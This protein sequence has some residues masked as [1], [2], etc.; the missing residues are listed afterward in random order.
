MET[1]TCGKKVL[2]WTIG[3][4]VVPPVIW[5]LGAWYFEVCSLGQMLALAFTPLLWIYVTAYIGG[6]AGLTIHH[7]NRV[8]ACQAQPSPDRILQAQ[9]SLAFL[10]IL[11]LVAIAIYC[12]VGPNAALYGKEFLE[13]TRYILVWLLG[14][15]IIFIFS[16]P[17]FL[18]ILANLERMSAGIP[19]STTFKF[20]SL[21]SRMLLIF[22]FTT[23]GAGFVLAL[24]S[25]CVV[26]G[27]TGADLFGTLVTKIFVSGVVIVAIAALNLFLLVR[28]VLTPIRHIADTTLSLAHGG[29]MDDL[30]ALGRRD[31]LGDIAASVKTFAGI[32]AERR[33]LAAREEGQKRQ[34]EEER[35]AALRQMA[36]L[37]ESEVGS[38]IG[39]VTA[40]AQGLRASAG[41][42]AS[43]AT[44][45]SDRASTVARAAEHASAN[46]QTVASATE[47][48][49]SSISEISGQV[50][51]SARI[52]GLAVQQAE[53]THGQVQGL[54]QA[55]QKIGNVVMLINDIAS[56]TN[57]LALNATIEAARAGEAGKG[58]AVVAS[59]VKN[60]ANQTARATDEISE[61][62]SNV[63]K[64]TM[65]SVT[66]IDEI[67]RTITEINQIAAT[68]A[69]AVDQQG[70][71]TRE[72]AR[73]VDQA[74]SG[75]LEV[76]TNINGVS[77]A[78]AETGH[79][80][81]G[82][83]SAARDLAGTSESLKR[84]VEK[85][86]GT[87]RHG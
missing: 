43:T 60:L 5:L 17:F 27:S 32:I 46:V 61:Q 75:T 79:A 18:C 77:Q 1:T 21:S 74:S 20:L 80:A 78:A 54:A 35:K 30:D 76:T 86:L 15:P 13:K 71:A 59:E 81:A 42:M 37:F 26:Y 34:A 45:A 24:G 66:A 63:Q 49:S 11:F 4:F 33:E 48:L 40:A 39:S 62:I 8:A 10:P 22:T 83:L 53:R 23:V 14:T 56:Q 58:F 38:V 12:V 51:N 85:F 16:V 72:I 28:D 70:S 36:E 84:E 41:R 57:L 29:Q 3:A 87:V 19:T 64:E 9:R 65:E 69:S 67:A 55:A 7:L 44:A 47:E 25:L 6:V 68:I 52:A 2:A 50:A 82:I 73:G 31:E